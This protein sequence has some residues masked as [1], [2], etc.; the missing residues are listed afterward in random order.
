[1]YSRTDQE[2]QYAIH[3]SMYLTKIHLTE[4]IL[5]HSNTSNLKL[6]AETLQYYFKRAY[7]RHKL[8]LPA[9]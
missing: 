4:L 1:V 8:L 2:R 9:R 5:R 6:L 7:H 3:E